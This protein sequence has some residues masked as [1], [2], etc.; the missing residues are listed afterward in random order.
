M[1]IHCNR[2]YISWYKTASYLYPFVGLR[3]SVS[4][5]AVLTS[6]SVARSASTNAVHQVGLASPPSMAILVSARLTP[7]P[8]PGAGGP[9]VCMS[10]KDRCIAAIVAPQYTF[11]IDVV[12]INPSAHTVSHHCVGGTPVS[13]QSA[14]IRCLSSR[15]RRRSRDQV[16]VSLALFRSW[17]SLS[18][19]P[20]VRVFTHRVSVR[21]ISSSTGH[22][23]SM[24][25][26]S[27]SSGILYPWR[28][29]HMKPATLPTLSGFPGTVTMS[30]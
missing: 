16:T 25:S 28:V 27:I 21:L 24:Y 14:S 23:S 4:C 17:E 3:T 8:S 20:E 7:L 30:S 5:T 2:V 1:S 26:M 12:S 6:S 19:A 11:D 9:A 13:M 29:F 15:V 22:P 10:V 18:V